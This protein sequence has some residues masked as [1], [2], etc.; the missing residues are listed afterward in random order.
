[1]MDTSKFEGGF[2]IKLK[3]EELEKLAADAGVSP[4]VYASLNSVM[5]KVLDHGLRG[6]DPDNFSIHKSIIR[7]VKI[8]KGE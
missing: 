8:F 1:M 6:T 4:D 5:L 2:F 3:Q 7:T